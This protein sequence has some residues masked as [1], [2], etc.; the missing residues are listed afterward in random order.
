MIITLVVIPTK[1]LVDS[2][3][4][5]KDIF[6]K[7]SCLQQ[8]FCFHKVLFYPFSNSSILK[9]E[10]SM[11]EKGNG[12]QIV[13][14]N[15]NELKRFSTTKNIDMKHIIAGKKKCC[16][17]LHITAYLRN[18]SIY[19]TTGFS[20]RRRTKHHCFQGNDRFLIISPVFLA[21]FNIS[22]KPRSI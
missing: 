9:F 8:I 4:T 11:I 10:S 22:Q 1:T 17:L 21:K 14:S 6:L 16:L 20:C 13:G 3:L 18:C 15:C 19:Y 5:L 7:S 2:I 12:R